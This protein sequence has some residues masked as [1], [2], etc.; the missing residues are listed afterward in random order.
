MHEVVMEETCLFSLLE[1]FVVDQIQITEHVLLI[2]VIATSPTSCCPVCSQESSSIHCHYHW[3]VRDVPCA[4]HRVQLLLSVRKFSCH[5]LSCERKVFA[6]RLF[7]GIA[8]NY[9]SEHDAAAFVLS[10]QER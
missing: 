5:N 6:E 4:G 8:K 7:T 2:E 9:L 3:T 10:S 1:G